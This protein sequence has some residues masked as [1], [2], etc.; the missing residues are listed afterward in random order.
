M[1]DIKFIRE[2]AQVI[3]E[4][5]KNKNIQL[6]VD[7]LLELDSQRL[8]QMQNIENLQAEKNKLNELI[9]SAQG[10]EKTTILE[11]GKAVKEKLAIAQPEFEK[12][13]E[14][15]E[16]LMV[17]VP[18]LISQDTPIGKDEDEN[19]VIRTVGEP[20]KFDFEP[21]DHIDLGEALGIIDM[22]TA[23]SVAGA[24]FTYLL[25]EA[26]MLQ[27]A[28]V[29]FVINTLSDEK[30]VAQLGEKVGNKFGKPFTFVVPPVMVKSEIMKKMDR[31]DPV[32]DRYY[33]EADDLLLV[34]SAE[35]SLG[36]IQMNKVAEE[37]DLPIRYVGYSTAFRREAG[38]YGKDTRGILRVHQ[39]DKLEM[40]SFSSPENGLAEQ[41]LFVAIQEYI[42]QQL[43]IPYQVIAVC[44]GDMGKPDYRQIDINSWIPSQD[45]YRETH[46]SDYMTDFQARRL[47]AKYKK[48][49]GSTEFLHM[50]DATAIAIGRL[51]IA[52]LENFQQADGSVVIPEVLRKYMPGGISIISKK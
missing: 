27:F 45:K 28:L 47:N 37:K 46:T 44:S 6:D 20:T 41:D 42:L 50:N 10:E 43:Q 5:A 36:P 13:K 22:K 24:R 35:H 16:A 7:L 32:D 48:A 1:L 39:F 29:Q 21:K 26:A 51:L 30:I 33:F 9:P 49:D 52:I 25:G 14:Q 19:M 18:N 12:T 34:G 3:G 15:F 40:E 4:V 8:T 11:Q 23:V 2:N 17:K 38:T 31:F